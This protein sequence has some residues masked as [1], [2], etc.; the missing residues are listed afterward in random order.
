M[1]TDNVRLTLID[2]QTDRLRRRRRRRG[3]REI[4]AAEGNETTLQQLASSQASK[5]ASR[6]TYQEVRLGAALGSARAG[7]VPRLACE[8]SRALASTEYDRYDDSS[9]GRRKHTVESNRANQIG[10]VDTQF[11][12]DGVHGAVEGSAQGAAAEVG[13]D[14][15][16]LGG[17]ALGE[18]A[19]HGDGGQGEGGEDG[20]LHS[21]R[22]N[23]IE[24]LI[25]EMI[26]IGDEEVGW[27]G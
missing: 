18:G 13:L 5:Q 25:E 17:F 10:R 2:H 23:G 15:F 9:N 27:D 24:E 19:A 3:A 16:G 14:A 26:G 21:A 1:P 6:S 7:L 20:E 22:V 4:R 11:F 12:E 8:Q